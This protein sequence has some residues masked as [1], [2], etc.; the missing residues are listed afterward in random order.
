MKSLIRIASIVLA[1]V[2]GTVSCETDNFE[3]EQTNQIPEKVREKL[4]NLGVNPSGAELI[5]V[6]TPEGDTQEVWKVGD[7]LF[8]SDQLFDYP[9]LAVNGDNTRAFRANNL[10]DVGNGRVISIV[11]RGLGNVVDE[12][13]RQA[14]NAYNNLGL[15]ISFSLSSGGQDGDV[16]AFLTNDGLG[17]RALAGTFFPNNGNPDGRLLVSTSKAESDEATPDQWRVTMIHELGHLLGLRH[18]DWRT[19]KSCGRP[20]NFSPPTGG[21]IHIPGTD[22]S[23]DFDDSIMATCD[24]KHLNFTNDDVTALRYLYG[25]GSANGGGASGDNCQPNAQRCDQNQPWKYFFC[26]QCFQSP[27]DAVNNG[28]QEAS[29]CTN[30]GGNNGGGNNN[31]QPNAQR[32]D[33]NQPWK[34]FFC[35]QCFESPQAAV[36]NGCQE[37]NAC[38]NGGGNNN[39]QPNAQRCDQNQP[40]KYFFCG[41]CFESP[42]AAVNN[43]CQEASSC[44][45]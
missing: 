16:I 44:V 35:G 32:C 22:S 23:A 30:G 4:I 33:Q 43:G 25:N 24:F 1:I 13:L 20:S 45:N 38:T 2:V 40:W 26:G 3:Q 41:Q 15:K 29:A 42:Q 18:S 12:A 28:C 10:I 17:S 34:Y 11:S 14:V 37:A 8:P 27:Q 31:C 39:C 36:N 5:N 7:L 6:P 21:A 9:D 19:R